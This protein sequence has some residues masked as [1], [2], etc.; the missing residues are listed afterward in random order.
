[1]QGEM[2]ESSVWAD[3]NSGQDDK[4][5]SLASLMQQANNLRH[6]KA[7]FLLRVLRGIIPLSGVWGSAPASSR[8]KLEIGRLSSS[9]PLAMDLMTTK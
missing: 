1:M 6:A 9:W 2:N 5:L 4:P 3:E 7:C 8:Q